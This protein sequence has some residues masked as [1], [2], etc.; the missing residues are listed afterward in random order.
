MTDEEHEDYVKERNSFI[1]NCLEELGFG[2]FLG[3][4]GI[5]IRYN[6][7]WDYTAKITLYKNKNGYYTH[8][9]LEKSYPGGTN[10]K[11][12]KVPHNKTGVKAIFNI[13]GEPIIVG[14]IEL[15]GKGYGFRF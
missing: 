14:D 4:H 6:P 9:D 2:K 11:N 10:I 12:G 8:F 13:S 3:K 15:R 5:Y 7:G 1:T